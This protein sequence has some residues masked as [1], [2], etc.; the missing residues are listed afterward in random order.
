M[1]LAK[2]AIKQ[3]VFITMVLLAITLVGVLSYFNMGVALYPDIS[4]PIVSVSVSFPGASPQDVE[5]LVTKPLE[6]SLST[7]NGVDSLSSTSSEGSSN[8]M[9]S[10]LVGYDMQQGAEEVRE[11]LDTVRRNLPE[12]A[13]DPIMR[14]FDPNTMPF[15]T[16][17]LTVSGNFSPIELRQMIEQVVEP[18]LSQIPGVAAATVSGYQVQDIGVGLSARRLKALHVTPTQVVAALKTQNVIIPSGSIA[19]A[20]EDIPLRTSAAFKNLD[21]IGNIVVAQYGTRVVRLKE[22]STIA[23]V[24]ESATTL[25]RVNGKSAMVLELQSQSGSNVVQT[26]ALARE[27][28]KSL[29]QDFPQLQFTVLND[30]STF[31]QESDR[32]VMLS[33]IIGALLAAFV[34]FLFVRDARNTI[35]TVAGLPVIVLGTFAII[36]LLG[37]T[38][39]IITLMALSLSIGLLIDDAIVVREN[40]F[41]HMEDGES[42]RNAADKGTSEIAFAV[43]AISLTLVAV[44][45]PVAFTTGQI[46]RLFKEFGITVS[47][48][49]LLS[50]FEAFTFAP[51]LTA[52]FAKQLK[53]TSNQTTTQ[54][55]RGLLSRW[56]TI[57]QSVNTEYKGILAWSLSHRKTVV[58]IALV[59][60]IPSMWVLSILPVS[61]FPGT[62]E[63]RISIGVNLPPG[64]PLEKTDELARQAEQVIMAQPKVRNVYTRVGSSSSPYQGSISIRLVPGSDTDA[65]ITTLRKSLSQY[66][67]TLSFG[68]PSQFLGV[69]GGMG[70]ANVRGR[71]VQIA[72]QGPVSQDALV[73]ATEQVMERISPVPGLRDV[74][75]SV[76]PQE[77]EIDIIVDRQRCANAGISASVVGNTISTLVQG[78]VAT[79]M[80]W[81]GQLTDVKVQLSTEDLLD[82]TALMNLTISG[83]NGTLYPLSAVADIKRGT[84][85][86]VLSRRNQQSVIIIGANLEGRTQGTV[87]QDIKKVLSGFSLPPGVTWQFSG[88]QAQAQTAYTSLIIA[89]L[90]GLVFVY[91]VLGSQ[92]ASFI[93]P[94]TVMVALPLAMVGAVVMMLITRTEL[95]VISMIGII[96]MVGLATKNSILLVDFIIRHRKQGQSRTKATLEAGPLRLRPIIM[97]SMAIIIG[98]LP[99]ALGLGAAGSF[100]APMAIAVI[101][102][103]F[104]STILSLVVVPVAYTLIDDAIIAVSRLFNWGTIAAESSEASL[105]A[106]DKPGQDEDIEN[107]PSVLINW[108]SQKLGPVRDRTSVSMRSLGLNSVKSWLFRKRSD[109]GKMKT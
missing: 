84:G 90:L 53:T 12:G 27:E 83:T 61:F 14:R 13:K 99:T 106:M 56:A 1:P 102:G 78:T 67:R 75:Q 2:L 82:T 79:Q 52:Y 9:V 50:L 31:I 80:D 41:R 63:G 81:E 107:A 16:A 19:S 88:Q 46:G 23:P 29:S 62:D 33:L 96:L 69:G 86:T 20:T 45:I 66:G 3:P 58:A 108:I 17:A 93:H 34:V 55:Q 22:I 74:A 57:W 60:F 15:L 37:F 6:Q 91:M 7:I 38:L 70:G 36:S 100:R 68:K 35:I 89:L 32:D 71:P 51:L 28:L 21:E 54:S 105:S 30:N 26:A 85:P 109:N 92:F 8:V 42:P 48:A 64:S 18:R 10:F 25:I 49:V 5:T 24:I 11:R 94:L 43:I 87:T 59:L 77:P 39:N 73:K 103:V 76:P 65:V 101:G 44:F 4:N 95:T 104:S 72:V 40:I 97:T 47:V 98:M